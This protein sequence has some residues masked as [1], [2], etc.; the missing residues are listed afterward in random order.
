M[1]SFDPGKTALV[2]ID[3]MDRIV[4][5]PLSPR[6][7][8]E[9]LERSIELADAFRNA[10]ATVVAVRVER[11]NLPEQPHGSNLAADLVQPGD[12]IVVKRSIGAFLNTDLD[13]F[14]KQRGIDTIVFTGIA[15]NLGV[16]S[17]VR[18]AADLQYELFLVEDAMTARSP[19]EHQAAIKLNFPRFG[20]ICSTAD[21]L[22]ALTT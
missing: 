11:P 7:G 21:V 17:T 9:V 13:E 12:H 10:G 19:E 5:L 15:T 20:T 14:L 18:V 4:A 2:T 1:V 22:A 16:E 6:P 8:T 3:L